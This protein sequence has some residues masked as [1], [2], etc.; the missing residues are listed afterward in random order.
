MPASANETARAFLRENGTYLF[1]HKGS[2]VLAAKLRSL[3]IQRRLHTTG[4]RLGPQ[5]KLA[6]L[7]HTRIGR[8]LRTGRG[9]W[10][11]AITH[12]AGETYFPQITLG[13]DCH[14]SN[15]VHIACTNR[16]TLGDNLLCGSNVLI[17]DHAHGLYGGPI[18]TPPNI[19]PKHRTLNRDGVIFIGNNVWIGDGCIVL[20]GANI[21]DGCVLG[22]NSLI[23]HTLPANTLCVGVPAHPIRQWSESTQSWQLI[24]PSG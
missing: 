5:H 4:L 16:V 2:E 22:A 23:R 15:N 12:S 21:G 9:F 14:L 6:G 19:P 11:E 7:A 3:F 8:N 24:H 13:D 1:A 20:A 18:Q 10:L 17:T